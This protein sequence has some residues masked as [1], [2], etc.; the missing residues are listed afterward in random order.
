MENSNGDRIDF[1]LW[2][3]G[4]ILLEAVAQVNPNLIVVINAPAVINVPWLDKVKA[5]IFSGFPWAESGH[6]IADVLFIVFN[7]IGHLPYVWGT[8]DD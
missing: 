6:A 7:P 4:N 2:H 3:K 1:D 8:M 5:V